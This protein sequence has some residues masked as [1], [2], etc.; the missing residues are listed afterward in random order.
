M[1][2][3]RCTEEAEV[4]QAREE[5]ATQVNSEIL[6]AVRSLAQSEGRQLQALDLPDPFERLEA[7]MRANLR[8]RLDVGQLAARVHMS[9]RQFTRR[10]AAAFSATP[11]KYVEQLR[12]EAAKPLLESSREDIARI[13]HECG[14]GSAGAMRRA[15]ARQLGVTPGGYR[16]HFGA[17]RVS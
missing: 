7:W 17:D 10:F 13:A 8:L 14:F 3:R 2:A 9:P 15:F 12:V 6:S 5:F 11:Q 16:A 4:S 1:I